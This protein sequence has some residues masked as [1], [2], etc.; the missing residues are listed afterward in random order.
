VFSETKLI[1]FG[2]KKLFISLIS[3]THRE[4]KKPKR[5]DLKLDAVMVI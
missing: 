3:N 1:Y 4:K 2:S 5:G